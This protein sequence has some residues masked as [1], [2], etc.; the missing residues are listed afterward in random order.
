MTVGDNERAVQLAEEV[1]GS[2]HFS[3][4]QDYRGIF[5]GGSNTETIF[6][7]A[8]IRGEGVPPGGLFTPTNYPRGGSYFWVP[9][10]EAMDM[11]SGDRRASAVFTFFGN[12]PMANKHPGGL[13]GGDPIQ[14]SRIAELYLISAEAQGPAGISRLNE[15][16]SIRGLP[17]I[18]ISDEDEYLYAILDERNKELIWE[19]F[20]FYD[21][22][23]TGKAL[24]VLEHFDSEH[25]L[26]LPIPLREMNL[27]PNLVQNP[28]YF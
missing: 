21:L 23:R 6:A 5:H 7:F 28:G 17:A 8:N 19:N 15:L 9:T 1:I 26:R 4:S 14:V 18:N 25:L 16:R 20:R 24:E 3:L 27:N 2:G 13:Q 10:Q 11:F 22:V 12:L